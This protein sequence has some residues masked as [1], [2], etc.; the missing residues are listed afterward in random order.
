MMALD[1]LLQQQM[2][3]DKVMPWGMYKPGNKDCH[4]HIDTLLASVGEPLTT[5]TRY[6]ER[7]EDHWLSKYIG[8]AL[9]KYSVFPEKPIFST[10]AHGTRPQQEVDVPHGR[11]DA[12]ATRG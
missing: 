11:P 12:A 5:V 2:P 4:T 8:G 10:T 1:R 6:T 3:W 9:H 7:E